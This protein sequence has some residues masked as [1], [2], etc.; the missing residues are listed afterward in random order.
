MGWAGQFRSPRCWYFWGRDPREV[1]WSSDSQLW[2]HI[3]APCIIFLKILVSGHLPEPN[4]LES[5]GV[6]LAPGR[7]GTRMRQ[8]RFLWHKM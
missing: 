4:S 6:G 3:L 8:A 5:L 7:I 2:L 1:I